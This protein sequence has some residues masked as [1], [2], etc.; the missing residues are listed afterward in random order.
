MRGELAN[1][2]PY[3]YA[4]PDF[5]FLCPNGFE[6]A[7]TT[8]PTSPQQLPLSLGGIF[9]RIISPH[10]WR[11]ARYIPVGGISAGFC[12]AAV[13]LLLS[14]G[15]GQVIFIED[16]RTQ[17]IHATPRDSVTRLQSDIDQG[18]VSLTFDA[19]LGYL[20]ALLSALHLSK[21]SQVVV[22]SKTSVQK[23]LISPESPRCLYFNDTTYVGYLPG[24]RAMEI[25]T[26][27]PYLGAV[28]YTLL[29]R[30]VPKPRFFR[31]IDA[32]LECHADKTM[33]H[34]PAHIMYSAYCSSDGSVLPGTVPTRITG[35]TPLALQ[36]GGWFVTGS[37]AHQTHLGNCF[38]T[39]HDGRVTV[40][41]SKLIP[42]GLQD[43]T[44]V[45]DTAQLL[46]PFSDIVA[47]LTFGHQQRLQNLISDATYQTN[48]AIALER[49]YPH[50]EKLDRSG[51]TETT[52]QIVKRVCEPVVA[53]LLYADEPPMNGEI[54]GTSGFARYFSSLAPGDG[55]GR[56]LR[57]FDLKRRL[58]RYPCSY[59]IYSDSFDALPLPAKQF[60]Y[61][62]LW[63]VLNGRDHS[64]PYSKFT[65]EE[66]RAVREILIE[67]KPEFA[68]SRPKVSTKLSDGARLPLRL[69]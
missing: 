62:R 38:F 10:H 17:Y 37:G 31:T 66:C 7:P 46:T 14:T 54:T 49:L 32:C 11:R 19:R 25:C 59:L 2:Y 26:S 1:L 39:E 55:H 16:A 27:E 33:S 42:K 48:S 22:F 35:A 8:L 6:M 43:L 50:R 34:L 61:R 9:A 23:E 57:M 45:T 5:D 56:S 41:D 65:V 28:Y 24:A 51:H 47:L 63:D 18:K 3:K 29:Q 36:F 69:R 60:V 67:T 12:V 21:T 68:E 4:Q 15:T 53:G 40:D 30:E 20:P 13:C 64:G 58:F 44:A 52:E